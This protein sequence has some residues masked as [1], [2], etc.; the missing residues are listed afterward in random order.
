MPDKDHRP[1]LPV[2]WHVESADKPQ[3]PHHFS[4]SCSP[5]ATPTPA[6]PSAAA[7]A[8]AAIV[9][10]E[11]M[12]ESAPTLESAAAQSTTQTNEA[13]RGGIEHHGLCSK[14]VANPKERSVC[15]S[16]GALPCHP[17]RNSQTSMHLHISPV[18][19]YVRNLPRV[20]KQHGD[21]SGH[22]VSQLQWCISKVT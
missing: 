2:T 20:V 15:T 17:I 6:V 5:P 11:Q 10:L 21:R 12:K 14:S 18:G 16:C 9:A 1:A 7:E 3:S 8:T 13:K 19:A 22:C 4:G